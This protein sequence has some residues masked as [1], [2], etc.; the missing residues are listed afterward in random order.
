MDGRNFDDL[1]RRLAT[2]QSRRSILRGLI[3]GGGTLLATKAGS[4]LAAPAPKVT[5][6]HWSPDLG[7]YELISVS[8]N[9]VSAHAAH[10]H[11]LDI[12]NP[13]FTS[14]DTCGDCNT[15]CQAAD[16]CTPAACTDDGCNAVSACISPETCGGELPG[17][18]GC[19]SDDLDVTCEGLCGEQTDNCDR[20]VDCGDCCDCIDKE[21]GDDG[22]GISC[23]ECK[24]GTVCNAS[25]TCQP[26]SV[27]GNYDLTC[28][29]DSQWITCLTACNTEDEVFCLADRPCSMDPPCASSTD[30]P[31]GEHC[32][33]G[34]CC[35]T[36]ICVPVCD[37]LG[38][39]F[40][41]P[42]SVKSDGPTPART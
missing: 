35:E 28:G 4:S 38:A 42:E 10:Q 25:Q 24:T 1:T 39:Q 6:C 30:C 22:C 7:Y 19:T 17:E 36:P 34:S 20:V 23:G 21:C 16:F 8:Q 37:G 32:L 14:T 31:A 2:G 41:A 26:C 9:A 18:C 29:T 11:G 13:D 40:A 3:G 12:I 5:I 33:A 27:C 15:V